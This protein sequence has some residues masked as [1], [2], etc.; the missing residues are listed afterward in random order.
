MISQTL[1]RSAELLRRDED[2]NIQSKCQQTIK[3]PTMEETLTEW[4]LANQ[5]RIPIFGDII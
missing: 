5:E 2:P 1:K 3:F 4:I